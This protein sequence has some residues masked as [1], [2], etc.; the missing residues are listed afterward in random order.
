M[1]YGPYTYITDL[2]SQSG[3]LPNADILA[4]ITQTDI[5]NWDGAADAIPVIQQ[6]IDAIN[7][8]VVP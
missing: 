4:T 7:G 6:A 1:P 2:I 8:E 3:G 5:N